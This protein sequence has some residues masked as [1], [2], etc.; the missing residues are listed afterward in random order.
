MRPVTQ[1]GPRRSGARRMASALVRGAAHVVPSSHGR[2]ATAM[3]HEVAHIDSDS[4]ALRWAVGCVYASCLERVRSVYLLD[5]RTVRVTA[6]LLASFRVLDVGMP[7]LLTLALHTRSAAAASIGRLT[8]GDD[9]RRLAPLLEAIPVWLHAVILLAVLLYVMAAGAMWRRSSMA[10][11]F[12]SL[13]V[14][15]EQSASLAAKPI[16][17]AVGVVAVQHPSILAAVLLPIVMPLLSAMAA[18]SGS[19]AARA[20]L[21]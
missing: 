9:Y 1:P 19:R 16:V 14:L 8:P 2:W 21:Y 13:A 4:K 3:L 11:L 18:C 20:R 12:W 10:A 17:A 6:T 5:S 15:A 7:T